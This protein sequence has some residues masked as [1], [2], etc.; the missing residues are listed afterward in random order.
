MIF[1]YFS[2]GAV[3]AGYPFATFGKVYG[4]DDTFFLFQ[5]MAVF[6]LVLHVCTRNL[7]KNM[8]DIDKTE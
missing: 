5:I 1:F 8:V 6:N 3:I 7:D 4:W 2:A